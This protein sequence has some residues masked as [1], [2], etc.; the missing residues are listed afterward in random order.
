MHTTSMVPNERSQKLSA[1]QVAKVL[2]VSS[3]TVYRLARQGQVPYL[4]IGRALRFDLAQVEAALA[5]TPAS[6]RD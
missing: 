5:A 3:W 1:T 6:R 2:G 4:R